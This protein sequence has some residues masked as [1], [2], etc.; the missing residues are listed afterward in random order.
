MSEHEK[1]IT[2]E[3]VELHQGTRYEVPDGLIS[4]R[5]ASVDFH[6]QGHGAKVPRARLEVTRYATAD[7]IAKRAA[8]SAAAEVDERNEAAI[9][10]EVRRYERELRESAAT[11]TR[12]LAAPQGQSEAMNLVDGERAQIEER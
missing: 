12:K 3:T 11:L 5:F 8:A 2:V 6:S 7:E 1:P 9:R 10:E 4:V